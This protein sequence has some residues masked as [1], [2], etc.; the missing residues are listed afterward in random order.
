MA[1]RCLWLWLWL[2]LMLV[3]AAVCGSV[4]GVG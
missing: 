4:C 2:W 3:L 1:V